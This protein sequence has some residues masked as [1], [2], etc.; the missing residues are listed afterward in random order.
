M[1]YSAIGLLAMIVLLI[2]NHDILLNR[3]NAFQAPAWKVYRRFLFAVLVY[4]ITDILW[5][6]LEAGKLAQLLFAD[7]TV[8]F[9]AMATGVLFWAQYTV[10]YLEDKTPA[11]RLLLYAGRVIAG[12]IVRNGTYIIYM[13]LSLIL[14]LTVATIYSYVI[15]KREKKK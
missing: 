10:T 5:G 2:V 1:Y 8:Y 13:I 12:L 14:F 15:I 6:A 7:T 9:I 4:Y 11:G 3:G